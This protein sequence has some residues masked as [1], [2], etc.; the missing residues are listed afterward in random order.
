MEGERRCF[1][2]RQGLGPR[3]RGKVRVFLADEVY[4]D[5]EVC[6]ICLRI[7]KDRGEV[8]LERGGQAFLVRE[9]LPP[10][11]DAVVS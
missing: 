3:P 5:A 6:R 11:R 9:S 8:E 10:S 1:L 2:C 4:R 7:V